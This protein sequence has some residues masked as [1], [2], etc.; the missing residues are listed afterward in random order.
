MENNNII[1]IENLTKY[2]KGSAIPALNNIYLSVAQKEIFGILGTNG[3][4]KTTLISILCGLLYPTDGKVYINNKDLH[5]NLKSIK[6]IIGIV[7]QDIALYPTLS[8]KENLQ[9]FGNVYG[10]S[11]KHLKELIYECAE[12][13]GI[14]KYIDK[15]INTY[16]GGMKRRINII[17]GILHQPE[18]LF[19]DEPTVGIDVFSKKIIIDYLKE[20]NRKGTTIIYT[21]HLM[22][23]AESFCSFVA[24]IDKGSIITMGKTNDLIADSKKA[25][26]EELFLQITRNDES[27]KLT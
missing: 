17:A 8:G 2:Y 6:K 5:Q 4:G 21:S 23:E 27:F 11:G 10:L 3:A 1:R 15:K 13:L 18:I 19:L 24:I 26:L 16:S 14:E 7:P 25:D 9:F 20:L 12:K 22:Q